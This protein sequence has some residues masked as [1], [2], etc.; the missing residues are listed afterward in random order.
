ME[1]IRVNLKKT[2]DKSYD[3]IIEEGVLKQIPS[4]LKEAGL[5]HKFAIITDSTVESLYGVDLS[6]DCTKNDLANRIITFPAGEQNK[7]RD[8]KA[9]IEDQMLENK[10]GRDSVIIALGGGVVGDIAG[11]VAASY[12]R[13]LPYVQIPTTLVACVDSSIGGKTAV[14]T[15]HGKNLIG[16]FHQPW[17]VYIDVN[18]LLTLNEKEIREGLAE[19]IKYGVISDEELFSFLEENMHLIFSYD[20]KALTH[21]IKRGCLIKAKVVE[22]DEKESNLRK[23]LNFGHTIGHAVENLSQYK[24]SHG[25]AI[26]IG[27]VAEGKLAVKMQLWSEGELNKLVSLIMNAGLATQIP[28]YMKVND[29][30]SAMKLDKKSR[31]GHIEMVLPKRIGEMASVDESYGIKIE[32]SLIEET[33]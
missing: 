26:S 19:V 10:F 6:E 20:K 14:D 3:I 5:G 30:I 22:K 23:I 33:I 27:M 8:T 31:S 21:I 11:Y 29:I 16:A 1:N 17:A 18:T 7:N 9:W 28:D 13:G 32:E 15:K 25:E 4:K 2:E 24:I 12:T